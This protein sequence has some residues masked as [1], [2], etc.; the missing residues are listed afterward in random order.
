[1]KKIMKKWYPLLVSFFILFT[2]CISELDKYYAIPDWLKG[3][4][5]KVME[6]K[7]NLKLFMSA[8]ERSAYKDL[9][10]GKGIITVFAPTD[11]AFQAYLTKHNYATVADIPQ[12]ELDQLIGFH[13]M[14]YSYSKDALMNYKPG[15]AE[16]ENAVEGIYY[17]FRTYSREAISDETDPLTGT[18]YKVI[19]TDRLLPV[20]SHKFFKGNKIDA[21]SNYE[22]MFPGSTWTGDAG[23]NVCDASVLEYTQATDNGFVYTLNKVLEPLPTIYQALAADNDYS[24]FIG[25]YDRFKTYT[26]DAEA[27]NNYGEGKSLYV[28]NYLGNLPAISS[29]WISTSY[30]ASI[31]SMF[32]HNLFAPNNSALQAFFDKYWA[33]YYA[34]ISKVRYEPLLSVLANHVYSGSILFPEQIESGNIKSRSGTTIMFDRAKAVKRQICVNGGVYGLSEVIVPTMFDMVTGPLYRDPKYTMMLDMMIN[35]SLIS[36]LTSNSVQFKVFYPSD[37]LLIKYTTVEG[38][39]LYYTDEYAAKYGYQFVKIDGDGGPTPMSSSQK[40][41]LAGSHVATEL[42]TNKGDEYIYRTLTGF[43]YLYINGNKVYSSGLYNQAVNYYDDKAPTFTKIPG[44]WGNGD[45]YALSDNENSSALVPESNQFKF[46]TPDAPATPADLNDFVKLTAAAGM[47]T[48]VP[49]YDFLMGERYI[50]LVP[51]AA[52]LNSYLESIGYIEIVGGIINVKDKPALEKYLK[53]CFINVNDSKLIDYPFAG[54]R[55][56]GDMTTFATT[57]LLPVKLK[58]TDNTSYLSITDPKDNVVKITSF[59]PRI[60]ADGAVYTIEKPLVL[61]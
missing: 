1:M 2:S 5:W 61:E 21:K 45:A 7:G 42:I 35:G 14:Q 11:S 57:G 24:S 18:V 56:Q 44:D 27:S 12:A 25:M 20:F 40:K 43:S 36:T 51:P 39:R 4:S 26:Y 37:S 41:S 46:F 32:A 28:R 47:Q 55:V 3:D 58:I 13:V 38:K 52:Q 34:D 23:F 29:E 9:V 17:K 31:T 50:L 49:I 60:F 33:P 10:Q 15:G 6:S 53:A 30:S 48:T 59:F 8:V 19:H 22:F 54:A 16:S